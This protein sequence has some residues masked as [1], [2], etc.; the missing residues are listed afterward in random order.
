MRKSLGEVENGRRSPIFG[1]ILY[2][3]GSVL[4]HVF[5]FLVCSQFKLLFFGYK[6][7]NCLKYL[8]QVGWP[9]HN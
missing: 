7:L 9:T 6:L 1:Q 2:F 3:S 5:F 8:D 4:Q